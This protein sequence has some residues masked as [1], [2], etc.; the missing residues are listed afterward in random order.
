ML[1]GFVIIIAFLLAGEVVQRLG[2]PIPGNVIGMVLLALAL[3]LRVVRE[4][5]I[6]GAVSALIDNL[7][8]LFVPAGVGVM[9]LFGVIKSEWLPISLSILVS[10][11]LIL[12]FT[13]A[14]A[15]GFSRLIATA[16][17]GDA[18][19]GQGRGRA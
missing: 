12:A 2:V 4:A 9:A 19:R 13:G 6:E 17:G 8:L 11:L 16:R 14:A 15:R 7:S 5:W 10:T 18:D 1:G 3:K